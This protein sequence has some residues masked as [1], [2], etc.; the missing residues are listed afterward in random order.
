MCFLRVRV[1]SFKMSLNSLTS[2]VERF[3]QYSD[4]FTENIRPSALNPEYAENKP[5]LFV[6]YMGRTQRT[7]T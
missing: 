2:L 1:K 3:Q 6:T 4:F 7:R 5:K